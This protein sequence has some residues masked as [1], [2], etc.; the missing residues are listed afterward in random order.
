VSTPA[1]IRG[2]AFAIEPMPHVQREWLVFECQNER[3]VVE[4]HL[5]FN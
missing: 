2:T 4:I 3:F 5:K 1:I